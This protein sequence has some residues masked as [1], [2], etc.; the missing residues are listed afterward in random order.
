MTQTNL[1][2]EATLESLKEN[3]RS[4]LATMKR[5]NDNGLLNEKGEG[6]FI[7]YSI[8]YDT[9]TLYDINSID[10]VVLSITRTREI[11]Y[12]AF[13]EAKGSLER[14][15]RREM[16]HIYDTFIEVFSWYIV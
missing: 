11:C 3:Y 15:Q 7:A 1:N 9:I 6:R 13:R 16:I 10:E 14:A 12:K 2:K 8:I 5:M 4:N